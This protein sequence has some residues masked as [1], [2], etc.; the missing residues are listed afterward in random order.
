[1][2]TRQAGFWTDP[3]ILAPIVM[4]DVHFTAQELDLC[5]NKLG[6]LGISIRRTTFPTYSCP[7]LHFVHLHRVL[8]C[9]NLIIRP[10]IFNYTRRLKVRSLMRI[11]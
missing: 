3:R 4:S 9:I 10:K 6:P 5:N 7:L 1:M 8:K 2:G 11:L